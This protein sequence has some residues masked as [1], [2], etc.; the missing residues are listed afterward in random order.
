[1]QEYAHRLWQE[2]HL[3]QAEVAQEIERLFR[4]PFTQPQVSR[5]IKLAEDWL[6]SVKADSPARRARRSLTM[7]SGRNEVSVPRTGRR[8]CKEAD[9]GDV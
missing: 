6:R 8:A 5:A 9:D 4:V 1:V 3:P 7:G 2:G